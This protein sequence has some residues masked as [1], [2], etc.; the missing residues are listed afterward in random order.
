MQGRIFVSLGNELVHKLDMELAG[1]PHPV[2]FN[3][4]VKT[5]VFAFNLS[6]GIDNWN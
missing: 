6:F 1:N 4:I 5:S 2:N 3:N